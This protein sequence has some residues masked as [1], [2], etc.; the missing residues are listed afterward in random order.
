MGLKLSEDKTK[1]THI[2]EG[3]TFLGYRVQRCM[4]RNN[5]MVTKVLIPDKA[6]KRFQHKMRSIISPSTTSRS[7]NAVILAQNA[8]TRGWCEYYRCTNNPSKAFSKLSDELFWATAHWLGRKYK[9][10]IP[11]VL[12]KYRI[13]RNFGT[14]THK[15][16]YPEEYKAKRFVAKSWHNPYTETEKVKEEKDRLK[17]ES[18]FTYDQLWSGR[19][20]R[21]GSMDIREEVLL[22]DGP[23]CAKCKGTFNPYEVHVDHIIPRA[24]FKD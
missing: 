20:R 5:K 21:L 16:I 23:M 15:L 12:Q 13:G 17:R 4:G 22:R 11:A 10:K 24:R 2:T 1:V 18:L 6:I 19:E 3:F 14:R 8:L 9:S 7:F